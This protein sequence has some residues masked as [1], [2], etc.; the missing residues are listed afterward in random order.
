MT[1]FRYVILI[2]LLVAVFMGMW[3][4]MWRWLPSMERHED[5][6]APDTLRVVVYDTIPYYMPV[7]KDSTVI[8]YVTQRL[9]T[10]YY[11]EDNF[12]NNGNNVAENTPDSAD[13]VIPITQKVY[14]DSLYRAFVSGYNASLD[15]MILFPRNEVITVYR[16]PKRWHMSVSLGMGLVYDGRWRVGPGAMVG[17]SVDF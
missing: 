10:A 6:A 3:V 16:E 14:E 1:R 5:P 11:K 9:P 4:W 12:P 2:V 15:S 8:R 17:V 13:V 7:P